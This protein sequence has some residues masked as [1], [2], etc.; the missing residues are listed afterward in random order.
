M[1]NILFFHFVFH[2]FRDASFNPVESDDAANFIFKTSLQNEIGA[3][4][5]LS[6][7]TALKK[8]SKDI[9][10]NKKSKRSSRK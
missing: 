7:I 2:H 9:D 10:D 8:V 1:Q 5:P 4:K 6:F 3:K